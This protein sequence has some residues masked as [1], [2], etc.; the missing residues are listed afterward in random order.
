MTT[1]ESIYDAIDQ[2]K[3]EMYESEKAVIESARKALKRAK[4]ARKEGHSAEEITW[5]N[6]ADGMIH[7]LQTICNSPLTVDYDTLE[8]KVLEIK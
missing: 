3:R 7:A 4:K 2:L 5:Y 1:I 6:Y 8:I